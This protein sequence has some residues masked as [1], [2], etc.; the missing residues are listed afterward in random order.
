MGTRNGTSPACQTQS[1][2]GVSSTPRTT[3]SAALTTPAPEATTPRGNAASSSPTTQQT[4][5]VQW[6]LVTGRSHP[7][8]ASHRA[9]P[10]GRVPLLGLTLTRS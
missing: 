4:P 1:C 3:S 5:P 2:S 9:R 8:Q 7:P 6:A 10:Q